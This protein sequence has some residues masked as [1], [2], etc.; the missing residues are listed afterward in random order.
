MRATLVRNFDQEKH[1]TLILPCINGQNPLETLQGLFEGFPSRDDLTSCP[2]ETVA[3]IHGEYKIICIGIKTDSFSSI[4]KAVQVYSSKNISKHKG[5]WALYA[6][7]LTDLQFQAAAQ[8]AMLGE[9]NIGHYKTDNS[10][11]EG[12]EDLIVIDEQNRDS[13]L[14]LASN[15]AATQRSIYQLVNTPSNYKSPELLA[16]WAR[17]SGSS[18]NYSVTVFEEDELVEKGFHGLLAVNRGSEE[19]ARMIICDY[20]PEGATKTVAFVGKGVTFDTGGVSLKPGH[21]MHLMKSDMGGAAA[22]LGGIDLIA[23]QKLPVRVLAFV[24][25]TDNSIGTRAIKPGDVIDSYSGKT[26]EVINTDA[27][28]RLILAD[29]LHYAV[30]HYSPDVM[31][32]AATL[33]GSVVRAL[34]N[35]CA[36]LFTHDDDLAADL[37]AAGDQCGERL[38][39]LP[40]WEDYADDMRSDIAD[41]KNLG[42]K[43]MAGAITAA[44]FLEFFTDEHPHWAHIDIAGTAFRTNGIARNHSATAF[45]VML[46]Y[47]FVQNLS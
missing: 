35:H 22:V 19:P 15:A 33:T 25:T 40:L 11:D 31:V 4:L 30:K 32:D 37:I 20:N 45:G 14:Q 27:E 16:D 2:E 1:R 34:G 26:I 8:G 24:P 39:R 17:S 42:D 21:N 38:W 12:I 6:S 36:G 47:K 46:F 3:L 10:K 43:P 41:I 13:L 5:S 28:G 29:A 23:K 18:N 7:N 9:Y 44:K